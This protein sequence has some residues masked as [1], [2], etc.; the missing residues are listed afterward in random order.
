MQHW[1]T[2]L[3]LQHE[4]GQLETEHIKIRC[5]IFQGDS[6]SPLLFVLSLAPL[7]ELL[8]KSGFG[9]DLGKK[10][11]PNRCLIHHL[12]YMDDLKL[13]AK[14]DR[15]MSKLIDIVHQFSTDINMQFG[16]DKCAKITIKGGKV[17]QS[18]AILL[19]NKKATSELQAEGCYKYLGIAESNT[20]H[21]KDMKC[22]LKTEYLKRV[23]KILLSELN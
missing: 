22:H 2:K 4:N 6:F 17:V 11:G 9:Y 5:G 12:F 21:H 10:A 7:S 8:R 3:I 19:D 23:R 16:L 20:L 18:G 13:Y 14:S 15:Q 1:K